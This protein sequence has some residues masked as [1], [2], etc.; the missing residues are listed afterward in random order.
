MSQHAGD[1]LIG[2]GGGVALSMLATA[3]SGLMTHAAEVCAFGFLGGAAGLAGKMV[4]A[5]LVRLFNCKN[6]K[7][8]K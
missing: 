2:L 6:T 8:P 5:G 7:Q 3:G 4:L 1:N